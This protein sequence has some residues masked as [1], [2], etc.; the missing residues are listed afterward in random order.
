MDLKTSKKSRIIWNSLLTSQDFFQ[1]ISEIFLTQ[2]Q[3]DQ[4]FQKLTYI[5]E[6][7]NN[8]EIVQKNPKISEIYIIQNWRYSYIDIIS[9]RK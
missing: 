2:N 5:Q 1:N 4:R 3:Q 6:I 9:V 8:L 7:Q